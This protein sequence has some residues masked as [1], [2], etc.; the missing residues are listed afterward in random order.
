[1]VLRMYV[2]IRD[3][4]VLWLGYKEVI[5]GVKDLGIE[6]FELYVGRNL[7]GEIYRDMEVVVSSG[8]DVSTE[9]KRKRFAEKLE[10]E[11]VKVCAILVE[12]DFGREDAEAEIKW[13]VDACKVAQEIGVNVVRINSVMR[14]KPDVPEENYVKRTV[15][16]VKEILKRTSDLEVSL[17]MENHGFIG[18]KREFISKILQ[19]VN[20]E[21]MGLTLDTG[22]FYWYGYPLAE[23]YEIIDSFASYVKHTHLKNLKFS[24]ERRNV[25]RKPGEGWPKTAAPLYEGD[26]DL[27]RI[28]ESLRK[29][30]YDGDLTIEDESLGN[31]KPEE[32]L[33][34]IKKDIEHVKSLLP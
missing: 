11:G 5:S 20:S 7:K 19:E 28:V 29:A 9:E 34:I 23:V 24:V 22:N 14:V 8:F 3:F 4:A 30:G 18:N 13:V 10:S 31:Y 6:G 33:T 21:R 1:V 27:G 2:S 16:C 25:M 15:G 32:R 26:I 12:N 17:A